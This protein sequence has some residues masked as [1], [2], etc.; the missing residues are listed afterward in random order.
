MKN[1]ASLAGI[2]IAILAGGLGTRLSS[3]LADVPKVMAPVRD[4]PFLDH[5]LEALLVQGARRVVL[6]LGVRS[7]AVL[8]YLAVQDYS[9]LEIQTSVEPYPLGTAG[10]LAFALPVLRSNPVMVM[11]GDTWSQA[12]LR[13]FLISH[14]EASAPVSILC[15]SVSDARRYGRVQVDAGRVVKFEEKVAGPIS[16]GWVYAG[17]CLLDPVLLRRLS[18]TRVASLEHDFFEALP[19]GSLHAHCSPAS[20]L[21]IGTPESLGQAEAALAAKSARPV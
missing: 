8:D 5:L 4:R 16:P 10:A 9:P 11:N 13:D 3:V 14:N 19:S 21:D 12:N 17:I 18:P 2:D 20:F 15:A 6:C 7:Q 1:P